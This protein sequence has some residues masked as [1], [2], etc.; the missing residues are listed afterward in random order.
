M[1]VQGGTTGRGGFEAGGGVKRPAMTGGGS[2]ERS[3]AGG[4]VTSGR[5]RAGER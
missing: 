5:G 4:E 3:G 1:G 2:N